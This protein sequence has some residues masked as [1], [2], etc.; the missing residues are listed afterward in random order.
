MEETPDHCGRGHQVVDAGRP[1]SMTRQGHRVGISPELLDI[2]LD[3][4][5]SGHLVHQPVV[6]HPRMGMWIGIGIEETCGV[7]NTI[8]N[9]K[10]NIF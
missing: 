8:M 3:P 5:E 10:L 2:L 6:G 7:I 4:M 9:I 1:S